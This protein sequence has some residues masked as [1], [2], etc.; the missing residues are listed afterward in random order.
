MSNM[1]IKN[2]G[3][4]SLGDISNLAAQ[5][6]NYAKVTAISADGRKISYTGKTT[7]GLA[8][9]TSNA[10]VMIHVSKN[11]TATA[12]D[13][14]GK[15]IVAKVLN[16]NG[17]ILTIDAT[18]FN[19]PLA[20]YDVQIISIAQ[21]NNLTISNN[22][23]ATQAWNGSTGGIMA[24]AVKN[25]FNLSSGYLNVENK[26]GGAAYGTNGLAQIGNAQDSD[27]LPLGTGHGSVF[28]LA[29]TLTLNSGS[30]IGAT[31]SG[32]ETGGRGSNGYGNRNPGVGGNGGGYKGADGTRGPCGNGASVGQ[33]GAMNFNPGSRTGIY[34][35]D[36]AHVMI[37]A[38]TIN[39]FYLHAIS[40]G[41]AG[42]SR[43]NTNSYYGGNGG[44]GYGGGGGGAYCSGSG[45]AGSGSGGGGYYRA[46]SGGNGDSGTR[47]N[48]G[49]CSGFAFIYAN[50]FVS[51]STSGL[52][53]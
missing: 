3:E 40:T 21:F 31:Y 47:A 34:A 52:A 19:V 53:A 4:G 49:G 18:M 13:L 22:N 39:N 10:L 37:I 2:F 11:K 50:N 38:N 46:G 17:S 28:V 24:I 33:G 32:A 6:N 12:I 43:L 51:P 5:F 9:I 48:A 41:G 29:N 36:G 45:H 1:N 26:G 35:K 15:F 14:L 30:R 25:T 42:G 27:R 7:N 20:S 44:A 8:Q 23:S 16:D